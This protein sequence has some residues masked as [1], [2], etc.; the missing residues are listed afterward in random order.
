MSKIIVLCGAAST[1]KTTSMYVLRNALK[2]NNSVE[3]AHEYAREYL[4]KYGSCHDWMAQIDIFLEQEQREI[5]AINSR[6]DYVI[7]ECPLFLSYLYTLTLSWKESKH[8]SIISRLYETSVMHLL[9]Y[10]SIYYLPTDGSSYVK[11]SIR[12]E[13]ES[14]RDKIDLAIQGFLDVHFVDYKI[15]SCPNKERANE[16]L[17]E[18]NNG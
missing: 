8:L 10:D 4:L 16:I 7:F 17:K 9:R 13:A 14:H 12:G 18:I 15:I 11:D 5:A 6:A 3:I 2:E 1:A